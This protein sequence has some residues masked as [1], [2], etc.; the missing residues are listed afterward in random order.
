MPQIEQPRMMMMMMKARMMNVLRVAARSTN[1]QL[2]ANVEA[3]P[4]RRERRWNVVRISYW[5]MK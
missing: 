3:K 4:K 1:H 2:A 5:N